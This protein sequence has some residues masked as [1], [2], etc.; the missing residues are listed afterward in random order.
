MH[1]D[2][3]EERQARSGASAVDTRLVP[4]A[5]WFLRH[6]ETD[7]NARSLSQ[8]NVDIPLNDRGVAQARVA[9]ALLK[10]RGSPRSCI[11]RW[12]GRATRRRSSPR[13]WGWRWSP[14]RTCARR[15]SE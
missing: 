6:G 11:R 13:R 9:A 8:G 10:G 15:R 1:A 12:A 4:V 5:F 2:K 7:W 3:G 14:T